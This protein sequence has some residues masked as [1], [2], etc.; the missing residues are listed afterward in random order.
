MSRW[1]KRMNQDYSIAALQATIGFSAPDNAIGEK[2]LKWHIILK[3]NLGRVCLQ[4]A[5][6][7]ISPPQIH[8]SRI[9]QKLKSCVRTSIA[10]PTVVLFGLMYI[11]VRKRRPTIVH[12]FRQICI[13]KFSPYSN[14]S[15]AIKL[16]LES[17]KMLHEWPRLPVQYHRQTLH[18]KTWT[19]AFSYHCQ[20]NKAAVFNFSCDKPIRIFEQNVSLARE[21]N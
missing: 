12:L 8:L 4:H 13:L 9:I 10:S 19:Q 17:A 14:N 5:A 1:H 20:G 21:A 2:T 6:S 7:T 15:C 18:L 16:P 11:F 3:S